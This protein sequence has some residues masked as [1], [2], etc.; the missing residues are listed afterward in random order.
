MLTTIQGLVSNENAALVMEEIGS[1][2]VADKLAT[3]A[4]T[5]PRE[6]I[7]AVHWLG[8]VLSALDAEN[9]D[10]KFR[11][12]FAKA[13][14]A[15][16][17]FA[18]T[19]TNKD[20]EQT[21][22]LFE[23]LAMPKL[24]ISLGAGSR[25]SPARRAALIAVLSHVFVN[26]TGSLI[27][28]IKQLQESIDNQGAFLRVL[29]CFAQRG[30][31]QSPDLLDLYVYY[32]SIGL[33]MAQPSA[34]VV[35]LSILDAISRTPS[36]AEVLGGK[37]NQL[38]GQLRSLAESGDEPWEVQA[39]LLSVASRLIAPA[40]SGSGDEIGSVAQQMLSV[41]GATFSS[42]QSRKVR[43][44]GLVS[45]APILRAHPTLLGPYMECMC[46][47]DP[48]DSDTAS[49]LGFAE[50]PTKLGPYPLHAAPVAWMRT[51]AGSLVAAQI[52]ATVTALENIEAIHLQVL[53]AVFGA[54]GGG[55]AS[56]RWTE[57]MMQLK[58]FV[59]LALSDPGC[60]S[61][62]AAVLRKM[63]SVLPS[64]EAGNMFINDK[65]LI[66]VLML[67]YPRNEDGNKE[68]HMCAEVCSIPTLP[69]SIYKELSLLQAHSSPTSLATNVM[70]IALVP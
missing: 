38:L 52:A 12:A 4:L 14:A 11:E 43:L 28:L 1:D 47:L 21:R 61:L 58:N 22:A 54:L 39:G 70:H 24:V 9:A 69:Y 30:G 18:R 32:A 42:K 27:A 55:E 59:F 33:N 31:A 19:L 45:L 56:D 51:G 57:S 20:E 13:S 6:F 3:A 48:R 50:E 2:I 68:C 23:D 44:V 40:E 17:S 15:Y 53:L 65:G 60:T 49:V 66:G 29:G 37:Y 7:R 63:V 10:G 25:A 34:R 5:R 26:D 8:G 67:M 62:A 16:I 64:E 35:S 36:G 41:I 46:S